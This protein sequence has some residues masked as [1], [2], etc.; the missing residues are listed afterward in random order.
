MSVH[1]HTHAD[2]SVGLLTVALNLIA[3]RQGLSLN[4]KFA[5][6]GGSCGHYWVFM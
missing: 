2:T 1:V 6:S 5:N 3:L 4:L